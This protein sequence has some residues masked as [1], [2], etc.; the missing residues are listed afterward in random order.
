MG[1]V[2]ALGSCVKN[3]KNR[4][5][6]SS[7]PSRSA[8]GNSCSLQGGA[9]L[10]LRKLQPERVDGRSSVGI[11]PAS[12]SATRTWSGRFS[13]TGGVRADSR[14]RRRPHQ[15]APTPHRR[16][17]AFFLSDFPD[18]I[19]GR[20]TVRHPPRDTFAVLGCGPVGQMSITSASCPGP[21]ACDPIYRFPDARM[22][23]SIAGRGAELIRGRRS[24]RGVSIK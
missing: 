18:G 9:L 20:R 19:H 2:V 16:A 6:A 8:C 23:R 17:G 7:I 5:I 15:G 12:S 1:E 21:G 22:A 10:G 11:P 4:A 3:L 24:R 13:G 14:T